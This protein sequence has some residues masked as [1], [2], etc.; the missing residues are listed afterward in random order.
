MEDISFYL[1]YYWNC[2]MT[3]T[4]VK[5]WG[6][7]MAILIPRQFAKGRRIDIGSVVDLDGVRVVRQRRQRYKLS[8]LLGKFKPK[9]RQPQWDVGPPVGKEIW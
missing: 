5:K 3:Y 4:R 2:A 6:S 7:S 8:E 9:H 1:T